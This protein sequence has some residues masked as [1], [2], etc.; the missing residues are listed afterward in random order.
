MDGY[1][2]VMASI[3]AMTMIGIGLEGYMRRRNWAGHDWANKAAFWN[4]AAYAMANLVMV[5]MFPLVYYWE[6]RF[7]SVSSLGSLLVLGAEAG[8]SR[9]IHLMVGGYL[10]SK[11]WEFQDLVW[12][13]LSGKRMAISAQFWFHHLTTFALTHLL[14]HRGSLASFWMVYSNIV[15]HVFVYLFF[16]GL[17]T[18][19]CSRLMLV[20]GTLQLLI[21]ILSCLTALFYRLFLHSPFS[22]ND[23][24]GELFSLA[25]YVGYLFFWLRDLMIDRSIRQINKRST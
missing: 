7:S 16:A 17:R 25:I 4:N 14:F 9:C 13:Y 21:G 22:V 18:P 11:L 12:V 15:A 23:L 6:G 3:G 19:L 5:V 20:T 10:Y 2:E 1:V 24:T 8:E